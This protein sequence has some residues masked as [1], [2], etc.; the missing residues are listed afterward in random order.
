M[1]K[2][3]WVSLAVAAAILIAVSHDCF[4]AD[5]LK[6]A[7]ENSDSPLKAYVAKP[8]KS[9]GWVKRREG[10]LGKGRYVEL[11]L[12]SQTWKNIVWKHQLFI[13]CPA[14]TSN[15][16]QG[17]LMIG[18][19]RWKPELE[20]PAPADSPLPDGAQQIAELAEKL[21]AP[22]AVLLQVPQ[23]PLFGGL[24]EDQIISFT[25]VEF[26]ITSDPEWLLL[27]PMTKSAV[28]GMD[29]VQEFCGKEWSL[30]VKHFTV[31]G[32]S[33]RGWTTWLSAA[34][35][36]RVN[37]LAPQVIDM[38]NFEQ[39]MKHQK[40]TFG[41]Y[42]EQ[43]HDYT[44]KGLPSFLGTPPGRR[45]AAIVDPYSYR[46]SIRQSKIVLL[47]TNDRYWTLDALN[48]YWDGLEGEKHVCY[49][50]N[51]G[52]GL[53]DMAR[54]QGAIC[55]L[56]QEAIDGKPLPKLSFEFAEGGGQ[57][58]LHLKS[59][60]RPAKVQVW[61]ASAATRDFRDAKWES[62]DAEKEGDG[63]QFDLPKPE[64]GFAA[65]FGE[66]VYD[67]EVMPLY[68]STTIKIVSAK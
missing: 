25:F 27:L 2:R 50:P 39:Q 48:M 62:H 45:L 9:Y 16:A 14:D 66:A 52:H 26:F 59:D 5:A 58:K 35:D 34:V 1:T 6:P 68:L 30:D 29:A 24:V 40:E 17:V 63:Y 13:Y 53:R 33:K 64:T 28:R 10:T 65:A 38:L 41:K 37:S 15:A 42:S 22:V 4:A 36:P 8:D 7:A 43:L 21:K 23:Q 51:N 54:V 55:A 44:D 46:D 32:A 3:R 18:G 49:V 67:R 57:V 12:T 31:N 56:H 19:G 11:T 61:T 47:A 20:K 60:V